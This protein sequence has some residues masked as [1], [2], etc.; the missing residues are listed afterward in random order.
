MTSNRKRLHLRITHKSWRIINLNEILFCV[1]IIVYETI[2]RVEIVCRLGLWKQ[3]RTTT[4]ET[5]SSCIADADCH[6]SWKLFCRN[7][8]VG[9]NNKLIRTDFSYHTF[10][11]DSFEDRMT[12][13]LKRPMVRSWRKNNERHSIWWCLKIELHEAISQREVDLVN[14]VQPEKS[15]RVF[16]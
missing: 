4:K 8:K 1:V 10:Y 3:L 6:G 15:V 11:K 16:L 14:W 7:S 5:E 9:S 2:C 12:E 13:M